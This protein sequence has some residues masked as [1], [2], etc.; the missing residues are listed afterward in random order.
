MGWIMK[1]ILICVLFLFCLT[2]CDKEDKTDYKKELIEHSSKI[3][4][5]S[6]DA[7]MQ[8]VK[9]EGNIVFDVKVDY[10]QPNY[11]KVRLQNKANNNVQ[12]ILKNN[13][14]VFVITPALNKQFQFNSDWPLNSSHAYLYQSIVKDIT[15]D[16]ESS[17]TLNEDTYT[18]TSKVDTK[19]NAKLKTQKTTFDKKT[20]NLVS[21]VIYDSTQTPVITVDF[22]SFKTDPNLKASDFNAD[23]VNN[24]VKLEMSEGTLKAEL[25]E[26]VPTF[27]PEGY[28]LSKSIIKEQYTLYTYKNNDSV[29]TIST[30]VT[31]ESDILTVS[32]EFSD[33]ILLD[34]GIGFINEKSVSFFQDNLFVTIYND[35]FNLEETTM[36]ANSFNLA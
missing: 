29:Y 24:T 3:T 21:N 33:I 5:Y 27:L 19:T 12:V 16:P 28:T 20:H 30:I 7:Q 1:K 14:G 15:N 23:V 31:E 34:F 35:N 26:C 32:R 17:F 11:Y 8:V 18:I 22:K 13:D 6:L 4:K 25:S 10:L 36:I 2:S 9:Q